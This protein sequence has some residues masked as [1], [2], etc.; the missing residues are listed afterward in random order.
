[1][2]DERAP[3]ILDE[4][5]TVARILPNSRLLVGPEASRASLAQLADGCRFVHVATHGLYRRDNPMF[6]ALELGDGRLSLLD[7]YEL[8]MG[9]ELAVLSGCGTG[10]GDVQ[11]ADELIGLTRGLL[12][13][14]AR[15]VLATLWDVNDD[16]T[17]EFMSLFYGRLTEDPRPARALRH[18]MIQLR[19]AHPH[20]YYWAPFVLTGNP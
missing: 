10:L 13:A 6:S 8:K 19:K 2:P 12:F 15:S 16:S 9:V 5:Q 20:P 11:G 3:K 17:A 7:L 18:A 4:A 14:G 1:M